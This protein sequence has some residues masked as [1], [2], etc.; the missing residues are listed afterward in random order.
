AAGVVRGGRLRRRVGARRR[1]D[2]TATAVDVEPQL[3]AAGLEDRRPGHRGLGQGDA[4]VGVERLVAAVLAD[5]TAF[6]EVELGALD[7]PLG[8]DVDVRAHVVVALFALRGR[9]QHVPGDL[10]L[11]GVVVVDTD[12]DRGDARQRTQL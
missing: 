11:R 5:G 10:E 2:L 3:P 4:V 1:P 8:G 9:H 7:Q 6:G 12:R